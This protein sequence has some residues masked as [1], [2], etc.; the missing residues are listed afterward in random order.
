M[1]LE[2]RPWITIVGATGDIIDNGTRLRCTFPIT[3]TGTTPGTIQA[4]RMFLIEQ[5]RLGPLDS[6]V[7]RLDDFQP[8]E[9]GAWVVPPQSSVTRTWYLE[10]A[11][12]LA[13]RFA[14]NSGSRLYVFWKFNYEDSFGTTGE[15]WGAFYLIAGDSAFYIDADYSGM[16]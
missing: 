13:E 15:S 7:N 5:T 16:K 9:S 14:A 6:Q 2:Q 8:I 4:M 10:I 3:N 12:D 1:R 11:P